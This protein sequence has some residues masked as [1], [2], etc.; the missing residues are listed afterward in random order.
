MSLVVS[1]AQVLRLWRKRCQ[2][3]H[4]SSAT[5]PRAIAAGLT[6][7]AFMV[8]PHN[9]LLPS[10]V[11]DA[12]TK[13]S[14]LLYSVWWRNSLRVLARASHIGTGALLAL[15][16]VRFKI[17]PR[18]KTCSMEFCFRPRGHDASEARGT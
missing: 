18:R 6:T 10:R 8:S 5:S 13:S 14:S 11:D 12:N 9:G 1:F 16:L 2:P 3:K 17:S 15:V 7:L 4:S